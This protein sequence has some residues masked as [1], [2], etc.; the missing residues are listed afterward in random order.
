MHSIPAVKPSTAEY[1][2]KRSAA[3]DRVVWKEEQEGKGKEGT[4]PVK[5]RRWFQTG[6]GCGQMEMYDYVGMS[7]AVGREEGRFVICV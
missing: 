7:A 3:R 5:T 1:Y 4:Y 6:F 2:R